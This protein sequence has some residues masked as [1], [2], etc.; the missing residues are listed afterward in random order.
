MAN[1]AN[2]ARPHTSG[3]YPGAAGAM[4]SDPTVPDPIAWSAS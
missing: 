2:G 4:G 1:R 3:A